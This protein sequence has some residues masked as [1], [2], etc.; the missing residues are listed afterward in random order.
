MSEYNFT[1]IKIGEPS[2]IYAVTWGNSEQNCQLLEFF[3]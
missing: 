3:M 2:K 1:K